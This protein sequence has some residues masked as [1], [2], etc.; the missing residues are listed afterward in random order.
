MMRVNIVSTIP[1]R[2][3]RPTRFRSRRSSR[4]KCLA[5]RRDSLRPARTSS[6]ASC[7]PP[8]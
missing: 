5:Q 8:A 7:P 6:S 4:S 1:N 2:G 3:G